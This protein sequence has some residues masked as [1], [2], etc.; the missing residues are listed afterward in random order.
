M[1]IIYKRKGI[2]EKHE[3]KMSKEGFEK[4]F[5]YMSR[6][7]RYMENMISN[8]EEVEIREDDGKLFG[9]WRFA[10]INS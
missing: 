10:Q 5:G 6:V 3:L 2:E 1:V 9:C 8:L 4:H 7:A